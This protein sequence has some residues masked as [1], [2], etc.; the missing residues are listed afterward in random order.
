MASIEDLLKLRDLIHQP[1]GNVLIAYLQD[2][3]T[4]EACNNRNA[5]QIKGMCELVQQL[6]NIPN[7]VENI[8]RK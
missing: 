2:Y 7:K 8:K 5:E 1:L 6:K 3:V 4:S